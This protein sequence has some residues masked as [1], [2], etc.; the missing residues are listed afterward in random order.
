M[1]TIINVHFVFLLH[2]VIESPKQ[3]N[4]GG[5]LL[6]FFSTVYL[7][8][9]FNDS[10]TLSCSICLLISPVFSAYADVHQF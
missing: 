5:L 10:T 6:Y 1:N 3:M 9:A 7:S 2:T 4:G 8:N